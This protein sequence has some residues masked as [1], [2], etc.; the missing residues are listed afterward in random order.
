[1]DW[2]WITR[3]LSPWYPIHILGS[4]ELRHKAQ[5][6]ELYILGLSWGFMPLGTQDIQFNT[7]LLIP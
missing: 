5:E 7:G 6:M 4:T 1:M 3:A 2:I